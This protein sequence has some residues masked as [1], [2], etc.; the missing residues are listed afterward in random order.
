MQ[1]NGLE[2]FKRLIPYV[3]P[4]HII[5]I[6]GV[7][8]F[9]AWLLRTSLGRKALID[10][11]MRRNNMPAYTPFLVFV[12][13]LTSALVIRSVVVLLSGE[14]RGGQRDLL[15]NIVQCAG[16]VITIAIM[17]PIAWYTFARRLKGFGLNPKTLLKDLAVSTVNLLTIWPLVLAMVILTSFFGKLIYGPSY[18][19]E[20]HEELKLIT[21]T[22]QIL[23]RILIFVLAVLVAPILEELLFR[24]LFQ[25]MLRSFLVKPWP[26]IIASSVLF[27]AIHQNVGHWP[28]LFVLAMCLGYAYEK[29]GSLLRPIFIHAL[30]N[31]ITIAVVIFQ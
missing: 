14:P 17:I 24:G 9:S 25:T 22:T 27:A 10:S 11:P 28:A 30:F 8:L 19:L 2:I 3:T 4:T 6:A 18:E 26:A 29:S 5:C 23:L 31:G 13:W 16:S 20:Q 21:E 1:A 12:L 7:G 15:D